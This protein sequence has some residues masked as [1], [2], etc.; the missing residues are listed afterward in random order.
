MEF[1]P[2]GSSWDIF[3]PTITMFRSNEG[4]LSKLCVH[5]ADDF[6]IFQIFLFI[7]LFRSVKKDWLDD[8][9]DEIDLL[10][11]SSPGFSCPGISVEETN[12]KA[13]RLE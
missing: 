6:P 7:N 4:N 13:S 11:R 3:V 5:D 9:L 12:L 8:D 2:F 10:K 1:K